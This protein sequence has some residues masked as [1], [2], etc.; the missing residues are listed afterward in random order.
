MSINLW[1]R[2]LNNQTKYRLRGKKDVFYLMFSASYIYIIRNKGDNSLLF[3]HIQDKWNYFWVNEDNYI[4]G[5]KKEHLCIKKDF[6]F[7]FFSHFLSLFFFLSNLLDVVQNFSLLF[8]CSLTIFI[9]N[10][11]YLPLKNLKVQTTFFLYS[12][13]IE[14]IFFTLS[15]FPLTEH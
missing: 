11:H 6:L 12:N 1:R 15:T 4:H 2:I 10:N 5:I 3:L 14:L 9:F 13:K 7:C 8:N